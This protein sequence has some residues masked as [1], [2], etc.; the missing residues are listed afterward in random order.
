M[1]KHRDSIDVADALGTVGEVDGAIE[2]EHKNAHDFAKTQGHDRQIVAA[3]LEHRKAQHQPGHARKHTGKHH[4]NPEI[5]V[6]TI[7]KHCG[8]GGKVVRQV[9]RCHQTIKIRSH[10]KEGDKTQ[11]EQAG[12]AHHD[13]QAQRQQ[14]VQQGYVN[15]AHPR[16]AARGLQQDG[17]YQQ[18]H[19]H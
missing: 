1:T 12:M 7:R 4:G 5:Q 9:R 13:V 10:R 3:Q 2:V 11:I 15:N 18:G 17:E 8:N 6:Q 14:H 16:V 19:G